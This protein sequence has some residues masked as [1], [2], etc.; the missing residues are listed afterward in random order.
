[1]IDSGLDLRVVIIVCSRRRRR[2]QIRPTFTIFV[3]PRPLRPRFQLRVSAERSNITR[4]CNS[5]ENTNTGFSTNALK[6][7]DSIEESSVNTSEEDALQ[8]SLEPKNPS[9]Y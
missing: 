4:K 3:G 5:N 1:M 7:I 8:L 6:G 9:D 2:K